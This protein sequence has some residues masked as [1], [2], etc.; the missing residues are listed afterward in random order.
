MSNFIWGIIF[1]V[2]AT[3][4]LHELSPSCNKVDEK[5]DDMLKTRVDIML[6]KRDSLIIDNNRM[7]KVIYPEFKRARV[8]EW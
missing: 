6:T 1:G 2:I 5:I 8:D 7:L 3:L 4:L